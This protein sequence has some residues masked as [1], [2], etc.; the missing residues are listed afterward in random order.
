LSASRNAIASASSRDPAGHCLECRKLLLYLADER[1]ADQA[2][3]PKYSVER[4]ADLGRA[5]AD[6]QARGLQ[7]VDLGV[8]VFLDPMS[9]Y[10]A[11]PG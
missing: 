3:Q 11:F 5:H 1:F 4:F 10:P 7:D 6:S 9:F 8:L 2:A